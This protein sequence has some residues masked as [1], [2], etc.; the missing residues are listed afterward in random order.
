MQDV[1]CVHYL[2]NVGSQKNYAYV[3]TPHSTHNEQ[4]PVIPQTDV[5]GS[6]FTIAYYKRDTRK[7]VDWNYTDAEVCACTHEHTRT[8]VYI[9][10]KHSYMISH[11]H[12]HIRAQARAQTHI[13]KCVG[14]S[15]SID[16]P[17]PPFLICCGV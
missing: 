5:A 11:T 9:V 13:L 15:I 1:S 16:T 6:E 12:M 14:I 4:H 8:H 3:P 2:C 10:V 7:G 17:L